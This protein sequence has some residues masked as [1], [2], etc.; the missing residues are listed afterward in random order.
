MYCLFLTNQASQIVQLWWNDP[1]TATKGQ[2]RLLKLYTPWGAPTLCVPWKDPWRIRDQNQDAR[3]RDQGVGSDQTVNWSADPTCAKG[4]LPAAIGGC[5]KADRGYPDVYERQSKEQ[6]KSIRK[7][8]KSHKKEIRE[9]AYQGCFRPQ[10]HSLMTL[11]QAPLR[12]VKA[13]GSQRT[14]PS[15]NQEK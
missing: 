15:T 5:P 13:W 7:K 1:H 8:D 3:S 11:F 14:L 4:L 2:R 12:N 9:G 6:S 10:V